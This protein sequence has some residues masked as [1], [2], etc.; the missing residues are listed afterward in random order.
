MDWLSDLVARF[1]V[2]ADDVALA[3]RDLMALG[4]GGE[5]AAR[6]FLEVCRLV[7]ES[8]TDRAG[9]VT[10]LDDLVSGDVLARIGGLVIDCFAVVRTDYPARPDA[11]AARAR[12]AARADLVLEDAGGAFGAGVHQFLQ[13]LAGEAIMQV[14]AIAANRAPLVRVETGVSLPSSV[15]AWDLYGD[16]TR[17]EELVSRNRSG[18]PLLMPTRLEALAS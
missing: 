17:G 11:Q 16:P 12:I 4:S 2:G 15:M 18:T 5:T 9:L 3:R 6:G 8:A 14:S 10:A 1:V 7:G 13:R